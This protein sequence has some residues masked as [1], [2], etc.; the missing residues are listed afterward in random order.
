MF[1]PVAT[2][3]RL[4]WIIHGGSDGGEFSG[5]H[6]WS[7]SACCEINNDNLQRAMQEYFS[8]ESI[9]I[10]KPE[11]LVLS[12]DDQRAQAILQ[13]MTRS[14][15]GRFVTRLLWK[16]DDFRL[17]N[18]KSTALQRFRCL[19]AKMK[20]DPGLAK[21]LYSKI[22]EYVKKGYIR[23]LN[24]SEI[25][26]PKSRVWYLPIFPVVNPNKA[27]KKTLFGTQLPKL[28]APKQQF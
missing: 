17:P 10:S 1:Q 14:K 16:F 11:H 8:L 24:S 25:Q 13:A 15:N 23:K 3:T 18:S 4:G 28:K 27:D 5:H 26:Q 6:D 22:Q 9:G 2:K 12:A 7:G 21:I 19:E 20:R